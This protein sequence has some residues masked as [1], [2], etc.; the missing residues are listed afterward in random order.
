MKVSTTTGYV[1]LMEVVLFCSSLAVC[2]VNT[3]I[4]FVLD[5][6][7]S[8][9]SA[10]F[11][12]AKGYVYNFT[13]SLLSGDSDSRV[14]VI[15]YSYTANVDIELATRERETLLE[16]IRNLPYTSG[17]TNTPDALCLLQFRPWRGNVSVL[18]IAVVLTDG[19]SNEQSARCSPGTLISTAE[20]VHSFRPPVTVFAVGVS[21]YVLE[22]L[23]I[24]ASDP[25]LVDELSGFDSRLLEQNQQ[26][27]SYFV[28]FEGNG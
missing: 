23:L 9:G 17:G 7:G 12:A 3:D 10:N 22:E 8:V 11:E 27:R 14:G 13:E 26:S 16:Q 2:T 4:I 25:L 24:I 5:A 1:D 21:D 18:R 20:E 15:S 19:R 28:C 6:S